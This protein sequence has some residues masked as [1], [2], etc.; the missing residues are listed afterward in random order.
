MYFYKQKVTI[1]LFCFC[2]CLC[3]FVCCCCCCCF[4]GFYPT[5]CLLRAV[6]TATNESTQANINYD[7]C[8][9]SLPHKRA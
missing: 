4:I 9:I 7:A 3:L 2:F 8:Q 6:R 1:F 5:V